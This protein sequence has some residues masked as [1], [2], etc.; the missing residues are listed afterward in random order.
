MKF[1]C[2]SSVLA[3]ARK[4]S[5]LIL[6]LG[7]APHLLHAQAQGSPASSAPQVPDWALPASP[8]HIQVPPPE[9]FHRPSRNFDTPIGVFDGQSDIGG[10]LAPGSASF[11]SATG[12]YTINSAGYNIWYFR[13]EFRYL[14]KK[15][16]G[17]VS[18]AAD[19]AFPNPNGFGDRKV[20]LVIR[21]DLD[22]D[23]KQAMVGEHGAG[24]IHL[25]FR[26][27]KA[28]FMKDLE[29]RFTGLLTGVHAKRIGIEKRGD[30]I[31]IFV[32]LQGEP[33]HQFGPPITLH[34]DEPFYVGIGFCSHQPATLD[35][36]VASNV[37]LEN[38]AG[39]VR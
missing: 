36:V 8:T 21:Q 35:T 2:V 15:M 13:D 14:W 37:V 32:S 23:S 16:S 22:D 30:S 12:Q 33:L 4:A 19:V 34:F 27:D 38:A 3:F 11:D 9:G 6:A 25:A 17:D 5:L 1:R 20:V 18:F 10:P 31:A 39:K 28:E 7:A 26:S 24:M 29:Y